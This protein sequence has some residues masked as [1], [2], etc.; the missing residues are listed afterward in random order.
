MNINIK[1]TKIQDG[2]GDIVKWQQ[3]ETTL[4][5]FSSLRI[6]SCQLFTSSTSYSSSIF[7]LSSPN[8]NEVITQNIAQALTASTSNFGLV[9]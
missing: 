7:N 1:Y 2:G 3:V 6:K 5:G 8:V 4:K 9:W